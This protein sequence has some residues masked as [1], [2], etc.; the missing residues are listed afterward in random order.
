MGK[1][2]WQSLHLD[3]H[4]QNIPSYLR[5]YL[6]QFQIP[7]MHK[8]RWLVHYRREQW[9][10]PEK[11]AASCWEGAFPTS[12]FVPKA[13]FKCQDAHQ[14]EKWQ[15]QADTP[16]ILVDACRR[17]HTRLIIRWTAPVQCLLLIDS[18]YLPKTRNLFNVTYWLTFTPLMLIFC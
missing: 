15:L 8:L 13:K 9:T 16:R 2:T 11:K 17:P 3:L 6:L 4:N 18:C 14:S 5:A 12:R 1:G 10:Q 7:L